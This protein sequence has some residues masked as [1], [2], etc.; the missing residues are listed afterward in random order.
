MTVAFAIASNPE[1][2]SAAGGSVLRNSVL[3][4]LVVFLVAFP[5]AGIK[6]GPVPITFGY[7]ILGCSAIVCALLNVGRRTYR[8][9]DRRAF[10]AFWATLPLQGLT[11]LLAMSLPSADASYTLSFAVGFIVLPMA[12]MLVL[13]PQVKSVDPVFLQTWLRRCVSFAALYGIFLF[14]YVI[15]TRHFIDIPYLTVNAGDVADF[16][17]GAADKKIDRGNGIFKLISTYNNGNIYGVAI[18]MLL[19]L[20]DLS[21]RSRLWRYVVRVSLLLTLSR[22]VWMGLVTYELIASFYIRR[23]RRMTLLYICLFLAVVVV[24]VLYMLSFMQHG[25]GFLF[26]PN[27]GGRAS[28][29]HEVKPY[30]LPEDSILFP[31]EIIYVNVLWGL[32]VAGLGCFLLA[33]AGPLVIALMGSRRNLPQ[34][35]ALIVGMAMLLICGCSDG[36]IIYIPVMAFYWALASMAVCDL[37]W[38]NADAQ[39]KPEGEYV[40]ATAQT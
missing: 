30:F 16:A 40:S 23:L 28:I 3:W 22:T 14:V 18:L 19:P 6:L 1:G 34:V 31:S 7:L 29:L 32:G 15:F 8:L 39:R 11:V 17:H 37:S 25:A 10:L 4:L 38:S 26:D 33:L 5:K 13:L 9:L 21:Q 2:S 24:A 36:P 27:L 35:R 12:L 20:Y